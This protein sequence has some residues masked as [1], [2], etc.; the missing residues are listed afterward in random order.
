MTKDAGKIFVAPLFLNQSRLS[1]VA[2]FG[3]AYRKVFGHPTVACRRD[4][5][6][7]GIY[8][9]L[10]ENRLERMDATLELFDATRRE[11]H[12]DRYRF[13]AARVRDKQVLDCACGTGYGV[14]LLREDGQAAHVTGVDLDARSIQYAWM[15]HN[16][17]GTFFIEA[18]G[19]RLPFS[20]E[21]FDVVT[22]FETI[23][24]VPND[25]A[26]I[27]E[28]YRV[29]GP[30][31]ML[32]ISTPNQWPLADTP[33]HVREY[34]R[35]S[36]LQVLERKFECLE[37]YNQNSGSPTPLNHEQPRRIVPTTPTNQQLAECFVAVCQRR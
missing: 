30:G 15:M 12:L 34:N 8:R 18:P 13:A 6:R 23:E 22:S 19:D 20:A 11:F 29:L 32:I 24:H 2:K 26:L 31:G 27:D 28:F 14:R 21:S 17:G 1:F 3:R 9:W 10:H 33:F 35:S 4:I 25:A 37:L 36:F 7:D 16:P 5:T